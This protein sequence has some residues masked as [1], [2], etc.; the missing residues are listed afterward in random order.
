[1]QH[2]SYNK[3][4]APRPPLGPPPS[5]RRGPSSYY[6]KQVADVHP[7]VEEAERA[8]LTREISRE[9]EG[10]WGSQSRVSMTSSNAIPIGIPRFYLDGRESGVSI[11]PSSAYSDYDP[12]NSPP[13][14][15]EP[16]RSFKQRM[17]QQDADDSHDNMLSQQQKAAERQQAR[18][19]NDYFPPVGA[20]TA[21]TERGESPSEANIPVR[22][23]S[24]GKRSK[25]TL[26]TVK[27]GDRM[28]SRNSASN[29][30]LSGLPSQQKR[31]AEKQ[32]TLEDRKLQAEGDARPAADLSAPSSTYANESPIAPPPPVHAAGMTSSNASF[33]DSSSE[34]TNS[35]RPSAPL[36]SPK[37]SI[38]VVQSKENLTTPKPIHAT[39]GRS[40][41]AQ[42]DANDDY[43]ARAKEMML[44]D[45]EKDGHN[46]FL[47]QD[48]DTLKSP[49]AGFSGQRVGRR[50][51]ARLDVDAIRDEE[52]R[53]SLS[54]L[55]D[56][57]KRATRL[58]SNLDRGRTASRLGME[59]WLGPSNG[60]SNGKT[61]S[62]GE[63]EKYRRSAGSISDMLN[64]FPPPAIA[65]PTGHESRSLANWSSR[66]NSAPLPSDSDA[67][68]RTRSRKKR[69]C[70]GIPLWLFITLLLLLLGLV[71]AA[72]IIPVVLIVLPNQD[73]NSSASSSS[74]SH[75]T[76]T[77]AA[78]LSKCE[79][80]LTC[81]N[82]GQAFPTSASD[83]D[84]CRCLCVN[85]FT[86][87][88][89][90]TQSTAGCS[91]I[92]VT[93]MQENATI[94]NAI[95]RLLSLAEPNY[96]LQ[97]DTQTLLG[98]FNEA[99]LDCAS[100]NALVSFDGK[101]QKHRRVAAPQASQ[102]QSTH[103]AEATS[104]GIV[105]DSSPSPSQSSESSASSSPLS[106][107]TS[108]SSPSASS[109]ATV[110]VDFARAAVL[111]ILQ[112]SSSLQDAESVQKALQ[113]NLDGNA[114]GVVAVGVWKVDLDG[115]KVTKA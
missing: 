41:L 57:I 113:E 26:T 7:I 12:D 29:D 34:S 4:I 73:D 43:D 39:R 56:L 108:S 93:G 27:S 112:S 90:S 58:A 74:Q 63:L 83:Q 84:T 33:L 69:R 6:S 55:S 18:G 65:T 15:E 100:E 76:G 45:P 10:G 40:P 81:E 104:N 59:G 52:K 23:A 28:R 13:R 110:D 78:T 91:S 115:K 80:K 62:S 102:T 30:A 85:S 92:A 54:S 70:C 36:N 31:A 16:L 89:C 17:Q 51:P 38:R 9:G 106:T 105:F 77:Q 2:A 94:G 3:N 75:T 50:V 1:V 35:A 72:A 71:A 61:N 60:N 109:T 107:S 8:S 20:Q 21:S 37:P 86:G 24:L 48:S 88:T 42:T 82:G 66:R 114:G 101:A 103:P 22:Q 68:S 64:A 96:A 11:T 53:G 79:A 98:L 32:E 49:T 5:S 87:P 19:M 99:D 46:D 14:R 25:P 44:D 111:Y 67:A 97:L 47:R 95:P